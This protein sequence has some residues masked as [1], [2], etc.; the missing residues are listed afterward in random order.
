MAAKISHEGGRGQQKDHDT[1]EPGERERIGAMTE[2]VVVD[3]R[4]GWRFF[5]DGKFCPVDDEA[6]AAFV[7]IIFI[8]GREPGRLVLYRGGLV[9]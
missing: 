2:P 9:K 4:Y 5:I 1:E 6:S 8:D 7:K 3:D